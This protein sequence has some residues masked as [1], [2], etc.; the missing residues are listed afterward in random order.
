MSET[1]V[2][3]PS[4]LARDNDLRAYALDDLKIS[5]YAGLA[6]QRHTTGV[7]NLCRHLR[8]S[9]LPSIS[10]WGSKRKTLKSLN[11]DEMYADVET[12]L[13]PV[14]LICN[15]QLPKR[16]NWKQTISVLVALRHMTGPSF[17]V[18]AGASS[19]NRLPYQRAAALALEESK[20]PGWKAERVKK[21][22]DEFAAFKNN[23]NL[24]PN[25]TAELIDTIELAM[26]AYAPDMQRFETL[27]EELPLP[28]GHL[29][30]E[31]IETQERLLKQYDEIDHD[32]W[33]LDDTPT[34]EFQA[35]PQEKKLLT[36]AIWGD[37][38]LC[39]KCS[40]SGFA[41]PSQV[42]RFC[43]GTGRDV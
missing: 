3:S 2:F 24:I 26:N 16:S 15:Y 6:L 37:R 33:L 21:V 4:M 27:L 17:N 43:N 32:N 23:W 8:Q 34:P 36:Q 9:K 12:L 10:S 42:C 13:D 29:T 38:A 22:E 41:N 30:R 5:S 31:Q 18:D 25:V 28:P 19:D 1:E 7:L 20:D 35:T 39:R 14:R 11:Y 40:G